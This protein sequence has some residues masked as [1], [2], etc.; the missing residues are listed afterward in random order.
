MYM[1]CL[2]RP[3]GL[4]RKK[5]LNLYTQEEAGKWNYIC[6]RKSIF[7]FQAVLAFILKCFVSPSSVTTITW[8]QLG[9]WVD[10]QF[11]V[12]LL[13]LL[14]VFLANFCLNCTSF[15]KKCAFKSIRVCKH[16]TKSS[17]VQ[18]GERQ[19]YFPAT[20]FPITPI[21]MLAGETSMI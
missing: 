6:Y 7:V 19:F 16:L 14:C 9:P 11:M 3:R 8:E 1:L 20:N 12:L 10:T 15:L 18:V 21:F 4:N 5:W 17:E 13:Q 2:S